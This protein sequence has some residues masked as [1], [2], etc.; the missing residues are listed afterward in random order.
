MS[1]RKINSTLL[2]NIR[3]KVRPR[4][5]F[6]GQLNGYFL[7][8]VFFTFSSISFILL[9]FFQY[10]RF[11]VEYYGPILALQRLELL[12]HH[13]LILIIIYLHF[14]KDLLWRTRLHPN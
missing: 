2:S 10:F 3:H 6:L 1:F 9:L 12:P 8:Y 4:K 14:V 7:S 11:M 13:L 5:E